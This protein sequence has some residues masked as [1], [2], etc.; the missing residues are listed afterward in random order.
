MSLGRRGDAGYLKGY[1]MSPAWFAR[2]RAWFR[3]WSSAAK[4]WCAWSAEQ[5]GPVDLHHTSYD[6]RGGAWRGMGGW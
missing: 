3:W 1:L 2:R 5:A 4:S 6:G